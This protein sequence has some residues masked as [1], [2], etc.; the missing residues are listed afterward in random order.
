MVQAPISVDDIIARKRTSKSLKRKHDAKSPS[1]DEE[2][3]EFGTPS[4]AESGEDDSTSY[5]LVF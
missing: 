1:P 3:E 5:V 4:L 2:E